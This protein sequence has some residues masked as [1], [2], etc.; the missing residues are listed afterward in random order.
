[1]EEFIAKFS[2]G[3]RVKVRKWTGEIWFVGNRCYSIKFDN[4]AFPKDYATFPAWKKR[5]FHAE[6]DK[7]VMHYIGEQ[8]IEAQEI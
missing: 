1:M 4:F 7:T 6:D 3:Q 8:H 5:W 2:L